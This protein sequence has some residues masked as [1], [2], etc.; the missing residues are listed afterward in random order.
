MIKKIIKTF[1][2]LQGLIRIVAVKMLKVLLSPFKFRGKGTIL[3]ILCPRNGEFTLFL[4]GYSFK[5][6]L[7]EHIQRCIFLF[8]YDDSAESFIRKVLK[9]GDTFLDIGANVGFYSL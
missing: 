2:D 9:P 8:N 3:S 1:F 5:C 4:F 6:D 7:S